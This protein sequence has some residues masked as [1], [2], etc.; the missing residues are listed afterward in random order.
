MWRPY[1]N[2]TFD[3]RYGF[4]LNVSIAATSLPGIIREVVEGD[5]II[6][7]TSGVH[8]STYTQKG[9]LWSISLK[10]GQEGT[11]LWTREFTPPQSTVEDVKYVSLPG[12]FSYGFMSGPTVDS[13]DG[14]FLFEEPM[15]RKR[16]TFDLETMQQLWESAPEDQW[17]FYGMPKSIYKG[18]LLS[19]GYT[20]VL[21]AYDI[22]TGKVLWNWTSG[23]VGFEGYY[24]NTPL[25]L[26]CIADNKIYLY[27][28]EHSPSMP[29]RRDANLW[30]V[31]TTDGKLLW[32]IQHWGNNP[33]IAD[34]YIVD[35][36]L[37]DN[38]IYCFGKGPSATT[39]SASPSVSVHGTDVLVQ[40]T[41]TDQCAGAQKLAQKL[42]YVNGVPAIAD[43]D[44]E[45]WMEYLYQQR[46]PI[47]GNAKG[48]EVTLDTL[49]PNGNFV[50]IGSPT[51][52]LDGTFAY[53]FT[54]E[55]PGLYKIIATFAGSK[56]YAAS[57]AETY[58]TVGE[59]PPTTA[60]PEYP[61]PI[62]FTWTIIGTGIAIIIAVAI[63]AI[64]ILRKRP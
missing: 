58:V 61:Q 21:L 31:N 45:A 23:T 34:G 6:G 30:C 14:V 7:G 12:L 19:Y 43:E 26:G 37:F 62:D 56:S 50:H 2:Q 41:V 55:V 46:L 53:A 17:N 27:S 47:P 20:G 4:S 60:P 54:P 40:G 1:W 52:D 57:Y 33:A 10:R 49:D 15:S 25:S 38:Q 63:A 48:V 24:Q 3:G 35:I 22:R 32:K 39:V 5:H 44:Q 9:V 16:W 18:K 36:D 13:A 29:L 28:T 42:G 59:A 51:S 8:N 11:L 64:L